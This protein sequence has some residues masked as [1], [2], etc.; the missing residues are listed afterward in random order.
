MSRKFPSILAEHRHVSNQEEILYMDC[1]QPLLSRKA[2]G[3]NIRKYQAG[4]SG[5]LD[6]GTRLVSTAKP[7][8]QL[9]KTWT[10]LPG[11]QTLGAN[12]V[13]ENSERSNPETLK[14]LKLQTNNFWT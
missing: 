10:V 1:T 4:G 14:P 7:M 11:R 8:Q 13:T 9:A 12:I 5:L 3:E 2:Y 6:L